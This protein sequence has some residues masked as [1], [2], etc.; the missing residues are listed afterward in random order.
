MQDPINIYSWR[1]V[2]ARLT[3]SGQPTEAQLMEIQKLGVTHVINLG[4]HDHEYAL[5][6]EA[7]SVSN[8]GMAYIHIPVAFDN[9]TTRDF[10]QF[11]E[12]LSEVGPSRVHVHCIANLRVTAFLYKYWRD[13]QGLRDVDARKPMDTVW[14][15]GGVWAK[16]IGDEPSAALDH[17]PPLNTK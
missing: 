11:C 12:A 10:E 7:A 3:T 17:R 5:P 4:L 8:L 9:P 13:V 15:P 2:D 16:F 1:R 14:R 6:N